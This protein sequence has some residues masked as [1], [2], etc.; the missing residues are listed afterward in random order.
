[1]LSHPDRGVSFRLIGNANRRIGC[2]V[3]ILAAN[4]KVWASC[5]N[6]IL[7]MFY[8]DYAH[9]DQIKSNQIY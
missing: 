6:D 1:V 7:Q 4:Y 9:K 5:C 8:A 2:C 3:V